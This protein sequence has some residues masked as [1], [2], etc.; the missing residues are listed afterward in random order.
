M[1]HRMP[2]LIFVG[3]CSFFS[4]CHS[5]NRMSHSLFESQKEELI[6]MCQD[7]ENRKTFL[8][9]QVNARQITLKVHLPGEW[10]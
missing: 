8:S 5:A 1:A 6:C 3:W 7:M 4:K 9:K 2:Q 10:C